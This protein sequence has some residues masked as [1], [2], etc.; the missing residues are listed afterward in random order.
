MTFHENLNDKSGNPIWQLKQD[1]CLLQT[2]GRGQEFV[3]TGNT[4][5]EEWAKSLISNNK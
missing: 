2:V 1:H 4:E 5:V 3:I